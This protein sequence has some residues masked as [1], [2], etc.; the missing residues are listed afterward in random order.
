[1]KRRVIIIVLDSLG[2]GEMPDAADYGDVG[3]NTLGNMAEAVGGLNIPNLEKL[4]ISKLLDFKGAQKP[5]KI[6]GSYG[7]M[8]EASVGK[9]STTGH[10]EIAGIII[11]DPFR[12]YPNGFPEEIIKE[13]EK[14]T[15]KNVIGNK[16]ASGTKII[17]ELGPEHEKT[18]ALIVYTSADSVFQIAAKEEIVPVEELYRYCEIARN[19]LDEKGHKVARVIARP[20]TGNW[21]NYVR[22]PRRKDFSLKPEEETLL[23]KLVNSGISVHAI[24]KIYDLY[25]GK[26]ITTHVKTVDNAD[27]IEKTI[28]ALKD[29]KEDCLIFTNLVDFD[30]KYGHRNDPKGYAK[31]LEYFDKRLDEIWA[32]MLP[33]DILFITADHGCD[34]VTPSTDHS[35]E[36]VPVLVCGNDVKENVYIGVRKT[37]ADLGQTVTDI[38]E[39]EPLKNGKSFKNLIIK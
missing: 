20:F 10:W 16:P 7:K 27:G 15:G 35:R 25:A 28:G 3:S 14:R 23:D 18:G 6:I 12:V 2:I 31:A 34:P 32:N 29:K 38:F 33:R 8:M 30:M 36:M 9:D 1:M 24:G 21:P 26:G 5:E 11:K 39:I 19:L 4:G 13:F 37:F 22:T 17:K